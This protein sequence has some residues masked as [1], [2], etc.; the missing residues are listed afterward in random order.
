MAF[1]VYGEAGEVVATNGVFRIDASAQLVGQKSMMN[2]E[3]G[4]A[5]T[6]HNHGGMDMGEKKQMEDEMEKSLG[7]K[8]KLG[9]GEVWENKNGS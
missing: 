4:V 9:H 3:R 2:P 7:I 5:M 1:Y 6:G 8:V